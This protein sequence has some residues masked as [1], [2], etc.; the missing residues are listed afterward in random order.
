MSFKEV[1]NLRRAGRLEDAFQ[2][3]KADLSVE[4]SGWTRSAMFW[5][6][7]DMFNASFA[8][9]DINSCNQSLQSMKTMA[10]GMDDYDGYAKR[11]IKFAE[12]K[13]C[14][15]SKIV[16]EA[17]ELSR[18]GKEKEAYDKVMSVHAVS[19]IE[20]MLHDKFGW[21]IF[22]YLKKNYPELGSIESRRIL[23]TYM[24]LH[25]PRPS[26]LHSQML[27][28]ASLIS[29]K[30]PDFKF[31]PFLKMWNVQNLR[32]EDLIDSYVDGKTIQPLYVRI[33]KRCLSSGYSLEESL[34]AFL[35]NSELSRDKLTDAYCQQEYY[36]I[37]NLSKEKKNSEVFSKIKEY[38]TET[39]GKV[40]ANE[41]NS[42]IIWSFV[43]LNKESVNPNSKDV[44]ELFGFDNFTQH[45]W[46]EE[47]NEKDKERPFPSLVERFVKL[48]ND[49]LALASNHVPQKEYEELLQKAI[50]KYPDDDQFPRYLAKAYISWGE[51]E[52]AKEEYKKLL[53]RN[54]SFYLWKELALISDDSELKLSALCKAILSEPKDEYLGDVHVLLANQLADRGR[55]PE[56]K[57]ELKTYEDT[58]AKN[59]WPVKQNY[60][61]ALE[62]IPQDTVP[63]DDNTSF[64][65][66]HVATAEEFVYSDIPWT[67]MVI[68]D[69]YDKKKNDGKKVRKA[70]LATK[71]G[72]VASVN[73][74]SLPTKDKV[75][76]GCCF[77]T[78]LLKSD[79]KTKVVLI[80]PSKKK[81]SDLFNSRIGY[82]DYYNE[83]KKSAHVY[84]KDSNHFIVSMA[85]FLKNLKF[86]QFYP[87]PEDPQGK[88]VNFKGRIVVIPSLDKPYDQFDDENARREKTQK[89]IFASKT[90]YKK[91]LTSF[92]EHVGVVDGVNNEKQLFHCVFG[93]NN[94]A[95]VRWA[96]TNI[97]PKVSDVI[98]AR[99]IVK[100]DKHNNER[101]RIIDILIDNNRTTP[102]I[103]IVEGV[104]R[105]N[106]NSKG[107]TFGFVED[108]YVPSY[109]M[110]GVEEGDAIKVKVIFDGNR[111]KAV[112]RE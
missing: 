49:S 64:Y 86:I 46:E 59:S 2:M 16:D 88:V 27:N 99:Y 70:K 47:E 18:N 97:R 32:D 34:D 39:K 65:K 51:E 40:K 3:A 48:Y 94:D 57:R 106:V 15:N 1:N 5:V 52:K 103:K 73:L 95:L 31:L 109:L 33:F 24:K 62:R 54:N 38:A 98:V 107:E 45:D 10:S 69:V 60:I 111:W 112:S 83:E 42:K 74:H 41:F 7:R 71:F 14:P 68:V 110:Q 96:D 30:Y 85:P 91:A 20:D 13:L 37:F 17:T 92:P 105:T 6:L 11:A 90:N 76:I 104:V 89:G 81:I 108:Y 77:V 56:A 66:D 78:K 101:K 4:D 63:T 55:F 9:E 80:K 21:I 84:D 75:K 19:P 36:K 22:R 87:V 35:D 50:N 43:F 25:N 23:F 82:V 67:D 79:S 53:L 58:Y 29:G 12:E 61:K 8:K 100:K 44:L 93:R 72:E 26:L 102:Y 28:L